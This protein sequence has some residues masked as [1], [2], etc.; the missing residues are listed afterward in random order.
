MAK[1]NKGGSF[2]NVQAPITDVSSRIL[3]KNPAFK[4]NRKYFE[5]LIGK[6]Q[7]SSKED[8]GSKTILIDFTLNVDEN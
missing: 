3:I 2:L 4:D 1:F 7:R 8:R 5:V 6:Q